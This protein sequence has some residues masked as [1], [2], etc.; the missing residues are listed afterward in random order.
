MY[1]VATWCLQKTKGGG[2]LTDEEELLV[3]VVVVVLVILPF[4]PAIHVLAARKRHNAYMYKLR[5]HY[6]Y[7]YTKSG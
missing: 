6:M 2:E 7:I 5:L 3:D 4:V 1:R